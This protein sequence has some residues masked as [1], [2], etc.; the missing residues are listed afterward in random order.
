MFNEAKTAQMAAYL[1]ARSG[2]RM[3]YIK[4]VKLLYL[5][6]RE[7]MRQV[8]DSMTHDL[9]Y[10]LPQG[11][12]LSN[13]LNLVKG[14]AVGDHWRT[15]VVKDGYDSCLSAPVAVDD[16]DELSPQDTDILDAVL[17]QFGAMSWQAVVQWT[18]DR[19]P[20]WK[21][22]G[23]SRLPIR[24]EDIFSALGWTD[25]DAQRMGAEY[26]ERRALER[27]WAQYG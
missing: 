18:H 13:T 1:L 16:L 10:S 12:V 20:E 17:A 25:E 27:L 21:N 14:S 3:R 15:M 2:G 22:P 19:L 4:L 8:G 9:T 5:A 11:P 23:A 7:S 24:P 26:A 6:D